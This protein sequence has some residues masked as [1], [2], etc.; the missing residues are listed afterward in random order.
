MK[1][2]DL[3]EV[4]QRE[5][6]VTMSQANSETVLT[7]REKIRRNRSQAAEEKDPLSRTPKGLERM[8]VEALLAECAVRRLDTEALP[9]S[10]RRLKTRPQM[11]LMIRE[12]VE[13]RSSTLP[14]PAATTPSRAPKPSSSPTL[15]D[16]MDMDHWIM[17]H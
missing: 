11:I 10:T 15:P 7:L 17:D 16:E 14:T 13:L 9:G 8:T 1:K 3:V 5:L 6:G 12:D 2:S 4:A